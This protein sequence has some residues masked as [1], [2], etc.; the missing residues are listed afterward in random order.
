MLPDRMRKTM[1]PWVSILLLCL[2][3]LC[4]QVWW[5]TLFGLVPFIA[6]AIDLKH[7]NAKGVRRNIFL[8][9][10]LYGLVV[11]AWVMQTTPGNWV[12]LHNGTA[13]VC[14][15][16]VWLI[17]ASIVAIQFWL[18]A[19][20]ISYS[21]RYQ[22]RLLVGLPVVWALSELVRVYISSLISYG[23]GGSF[24]PN[25]NF[26]ILGLQLMASPFAY[27]SRFL[28]LYGMSMLVVVINT[29]VLLFFIKKYRSSLVICLAIMVICV[30]GK[31]AYVPNGR[32]VDVSATHLQTK[33]NLKQWPESAL[34]SKQTE[35]I[36]IPEYSLFFENEHYN[37][38]AKEHFLPNSVLITSVAT[39][40]KPSKNQL[41][42]YQP[43]SGIINQQSKSFLIA[44]GEYM[45]YVFSFAFSFFKQGYITDDFNK[46]QQVQRASSLATAASLLFVGLPL[47]F[48]PS[49]LDSTKLSRV[50]VLIIVLALSSIT[51]VIRNRESTHSNKRYT[52]VMFTLV[53]MTLLM[54]ASF[55]KQ[56]SSQ[57]NI[58]LFGKSPEYL[59]IL[60]WLSFIGIGLLLSNNMFKTIFSV[61]G[62]VIC[63]VT[64]S[65]SLLSD[66]FLF[67]T[68]FV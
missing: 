17:A 16:A 48:V 68:V 67:G 47:V 39:G 43:N 1:L 64:L 57:D 36:V 49:S 40:D 22:H 7:T 62:L 32:I 30:I 52:I 20:Y 35:L 38:L 3:L 51:Y 21:G 60:T 18:I 33:D 27:A 46:T 13:T 25:W 65:V 26:G 45:P 41:T 15:I 2:P 54:S 53:L 61:T 8:V 23:P 37:N 9:G 24:S 44:G 31:L 55:I 63:T 34:P 59:G 56:Y 29:A 5:I 66:L 19:F 6:Y 11:Y 10:L 42:V 14:K 50:A 12:N 4:R 28:G 58:S